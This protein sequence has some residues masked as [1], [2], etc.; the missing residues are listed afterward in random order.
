MA[1]TL[2]E[3]QLIANIDSAVKNGKNLNLNPSV[4]FKSIAKKP[5]VTNLIHS[6]EEK[7]IDLYLHAYEGFREFVS[8]FYRRV[9]LPV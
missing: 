1:L 6:Q 2:S 5:G 8:F 9:G 4:I 7:E 3:K